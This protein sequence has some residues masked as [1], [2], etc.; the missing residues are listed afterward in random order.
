M[1][2]I[3]TISCPI[4]NAI[5]YVGKTHRTLDERMLHHSRQTKD[6]DLKTWINYIIGLKKTPIIEPV[7]E[8]DEDDACELETFWIHQFECWGFKLFN[9]NQTI[10]KILKCRYYA[11]DYKIKEYLK[12]L[13]QKT[14]KK[15]EIDQ[16][17]Q[18]KWNELFE[19]GDIIKI[20]ERFKIK[21]R[22]VASSL[23]SKKMKSDVYIAICCFYNERLQKIEEAKKRFDL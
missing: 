8:C 16:A 15:M 2:V 6:S 14:P 13:S 20:A 1:Y 21:Y 3:Y 5:K 11:D 4:S 9:I 12:K 7:D 17:V 18:K 19:Q 23:K 22:L 10:G